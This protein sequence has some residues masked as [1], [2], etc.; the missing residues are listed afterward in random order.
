M[1]QCRV[2][3]K[4][5]FPY[6]KEKFLSYIHQKVAP[7]DI[8]P[9]D[10]S[11]LYMD[12]VE[13]ELQELGAT[14]EKKTHHFQVNKNEEYQVYISDM[15]RDVIVPFVGKEKYLL[16]LQKKYD[17]SYTLEIVPTID[18]TSQEVRPCL[19]LDPDIIAFLYLT[20]TQFDL[21]YYI[22]EKNEEN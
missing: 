1:H 21:D 2:Y 4:I 7:K 18:L 19:S 5:S 12:E 17:L 20:N 9:E 10:I 8:R 6:D 11:V 15:V 3:F 13:K 14:Y 22:L 16:H